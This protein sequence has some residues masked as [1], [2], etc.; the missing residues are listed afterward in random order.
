[1]GLWAQAAFFSLP[2]VIRLCLPGSSTVCGY[3][4]FGVGL[5]EKPKW[6]NTSADCLDCG[7]GA[8][9][10]TVP[11]TG[12]LFL[13]LAGHRQGIPASEWCPAACL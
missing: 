13:P 8:L 10:C 3:H 1:M 11:S 9:R 7:S 6:D 12:A 5:Q 2:E 4:A